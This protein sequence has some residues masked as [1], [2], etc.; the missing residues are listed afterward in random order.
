MSSNIEAKAY[1]VDRFIDDVKA[2]LKERGATDEGLREIGQRLRLL[3][4][5]DDLFDVGAYR[6]PVPLQNSLG[7]YRLHAEPDETLVLSLS[8]FSHEAPT[9]VHAHRSWG[10]MCGY[11]WRERYEGWERL[12]DGPLSGHA[13]LRLLVD[14]EI[15]PGDVVYW[16][17]YPRDIHRQQACEEPCWELLLMGKTTR[18]AARIYFDPEKQTVWEVQPPTAI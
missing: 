17:D 13:E 2:I 9:K 5:R 8:K 18:G 15:K 3:G 12:D 6:E 7:S 11:R 10:V 14:R 4:K 16:Q 1:T